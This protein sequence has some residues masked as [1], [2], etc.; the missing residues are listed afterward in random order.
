M[1]QESYNRIHNLFQWHKLQPKLTNSLE[2]NFVSDSSESLTYAFVIFHFILFN[3][4]KNRVSF[5]I[6]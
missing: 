3:P 2:K 5:M 4:L 6:N 1:I